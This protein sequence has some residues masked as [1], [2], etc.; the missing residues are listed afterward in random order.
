MNEQL[1]KWKMLGLDQRI[2]LT[3]GA[4]SCVQDPKSVQ[5]RRLSEQYLR[6]IRQR[7]ELRTND[8]VHQI[9]QERGIA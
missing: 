7:N 6:L 5:C 8:E 4:L 1:R 3:L 2:H 9:E